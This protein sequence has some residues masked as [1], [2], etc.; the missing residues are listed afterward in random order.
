M[1]NI[2]ILTVKLEILLNL[3]LQL[4]TLELQCL[5]KTSLSILR[6]F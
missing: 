3:N 4:L 6:L 2:N 5:P 1:S